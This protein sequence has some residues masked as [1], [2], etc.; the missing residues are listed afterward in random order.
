M[1]GHKA[2]FQ[3]ELGKLLNLLAFLVGCREKEEQLSDNLNS[4][5][6]VSI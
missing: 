1:N 3:E 4:P 2:V 6:L 5:F